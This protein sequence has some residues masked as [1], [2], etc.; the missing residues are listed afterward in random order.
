MEAR[1]EHGEAAKTFIA[2]LQFISEKMGEINPKYKKDPMQMAIKVLECSPDAGK[3]EPANAWKPFKCSWD[4]KLIMLKDDKEEFDEFLS[5]FGKEWKRVGNPHNY[6]T[7][8]T[9]AYQVSDVRNI[10]CH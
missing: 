9:K 1:P 3:N 5:D 8:T 7:K 6:S 10:T 2:E 4:R